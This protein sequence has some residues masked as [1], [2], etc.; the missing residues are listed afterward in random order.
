MSLGGNACFPQHLPFPNQLATGL[1]LVL[2]ITIAKRPS[3]ITLRKLQQK[4]FTVY[5]PWSIHVPMR[6]QVERARSGLGFCFHWGRG[7]KPRVPPAHSLQVHVRHKRAF[8][9]GKRKNKQSGWSVIKINQDVK[10]RSFSV[11]RRPGFL[12]GPVAATVFI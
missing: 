12:S 11:W 8:K 10:H 6:S 1:T 9:A 5:R 7:W 4:D 3:A 2:L